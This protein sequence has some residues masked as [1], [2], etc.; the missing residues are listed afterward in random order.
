VQFNH[1]IG[2]YLLFVLALY[3]GLRA[4]GDR[5]SPSAT[6]LLAGALALAVTLQAMLGIVTLRAAAPLD[7]SIL[8]QTGAVA[9]LAVATALCW[10]S[11]RGV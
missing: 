1:R 4:L 10:S 11:Q 8:H 3:L 5:R 6:R 9:V 2:A 7:L